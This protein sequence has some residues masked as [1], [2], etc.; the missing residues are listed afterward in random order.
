R[1]VGQMTLESFSLFV[2]ERVEGE[3]GCLL[4]HHAYATWGRAR[5]VI[6]RPR[7]STTT[8]LNAG[9]SRITP[10]L[11]STRAKGLFAVTAPRPRAVIATARPA[12]K[13]RIRTSP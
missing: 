1:A 4:V 8:A 9:R 5:T 2:V 3:R 13:A 12:L 11:K 6:A 10:P 7:P